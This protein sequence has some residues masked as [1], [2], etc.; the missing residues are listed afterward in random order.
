[1]FDDLFTKD[2]F[3]LEDEEVQEEEEQ[4][5]ELDTTDDE[6]DYPD[7]DQND[8]PDPPKTQSGGVPDPSQTVSDTADACE[9]CGEYDCV[10][11]DVD[12]PNGVDSDCACDDDDGCSNC[13]L[14]L[15]D[16]DAWDT[17][18]KKWDTG[19]GQRPVPKNVWKP[20]TWKT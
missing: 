17:G 20:K 19:T 2:D 4:E 14:G 8:D 10:C 16:D 7:D 15:D 5:L 12:L 9:D 3:S 11:L 18:I 6:D 1:M 13:S